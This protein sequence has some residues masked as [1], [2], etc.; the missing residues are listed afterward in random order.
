MNF[1]SNLRHPGT[2]CAPALRY[3]VRAVATLLCG[4]LR[5][6]LSLGPLR[7]LARCATSHLLE[8]MV[9]SLQMYIEYICFCFAKPLRLYIAGASELHT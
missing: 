7:G 3:A 8:Q 2:H 5:G 6:S 1:L 4:A 9:R